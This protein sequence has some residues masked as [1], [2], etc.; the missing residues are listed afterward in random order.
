MAIVK[1]C[2]D[3]S[4]YNYSGLV[5]SNDSA[6]CLYS[7]NCITAPGDPYWLNDGCYAWV[8]DIDNYCCANEWDAI[9]QATYDYCSTGWSGDLPLARKIENDIKI[10]PNPT[11]RIIHINKVVD[12]QVYNNVGKLILSGQGNII[13]LSSFSKGIYNT[14]IK[15]NNQIITNK[16]IKK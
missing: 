5:N 1:G 8:I 9:C 12:I 6:S 15:Y 7:A 11:T 4:A 16:I 14:V 10:F 2:M 3:P 13:D